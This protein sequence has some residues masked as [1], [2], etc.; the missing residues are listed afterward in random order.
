MF[1][2]NGLNIGIYITANIV[3]HIVGIVRKYKKLAK[4]CEPPTTA[5]THFLK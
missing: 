2:T 4:V 5:G 1:L 3:G